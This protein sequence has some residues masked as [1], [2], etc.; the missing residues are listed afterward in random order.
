M[1]SD[2]GSLAKDINDAGPKAT[3][4]NIDLVNV[5]SAALER[6]NMEKNIADQNKVRQATR[7]HWHVLSTGVFAPTLLMV[8]PTRITPHDSRIS[9]WIRLRRCKHDFVIPFSP[10]TPI[11][12]HWHSTAILIF[13]ITFE[14]VDS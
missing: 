6:Y 1:G 9:A 14:T 11:H 8:R 13:A 2:S 3:T 12:R 7:A 5:A 10:H 4:T